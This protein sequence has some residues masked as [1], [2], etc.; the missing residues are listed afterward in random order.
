M[1]CK[2]YKYLIEKL[3]MKEISDEE[4]N[5]LELHISECKYCEKDYRAILNM[6]KITKTIEDTEI[7][8]S[9]KKELI[10][11]TL[12]ML[13]DKQN[14]FTINKNFLLSDKLRIAVSSVAAGLIIFFSAQQFY[15]FSS[16]QNLESKNSEVMNNNY[17]K[18][19]VKAV[20]LAKY[21][22]SLVV[23]DEFLKL[24]Q[25]RLVKFMHDNN[26]FKLRSYVPE[27]YTN[28]LGRLN[29]IHKK[30]TFF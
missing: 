18:P 7:Q 27:S 25:N 8:F 29:I 21:T 20:L 14:K 2:D 12:Q 4:L 13:D 15:L 19:V 22:N 9:E 16:L 24:N 3:M 11:E 17:S 23:K 26:I 5:Q 30:D 10:N 1:S 28:K 6:K